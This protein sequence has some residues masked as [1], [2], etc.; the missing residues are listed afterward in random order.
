VRPTTDHQFYYHFHHHH[1]H[2][3]QQQQQQ[4]PQL[5]ASTDS[6][7]PDLATNGSCTIA[8]HCRQYF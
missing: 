3:Q 7:T 6:C 1:H 2:Q 8:P 4:Q 5:A